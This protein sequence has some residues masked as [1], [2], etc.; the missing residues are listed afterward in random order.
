MN[1]GT[2]LRNLRVQ[3]HLT[4]QQLAN[5]M[6]MSQSSITAYETGFREPSFEIVRQFAEYFHVPPSMLM[7]FGEVSDEEY[8]QRVTES[9][10]ANPKL[11]TLFDR[12]KNF[13]E[14]DLDAIL[15]IVDSI[16]G[17]RN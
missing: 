2:N 7:P 4:Q 14:K 11:R 13:S 8:V 9:L 16:S 6:G 10:H 3:R 1:F 17:R 5:D 12:T 15:A